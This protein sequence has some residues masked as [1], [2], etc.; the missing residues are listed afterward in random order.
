MNRP[1]K[2]LIWVV[3]VLVAIA[4]VATIAWRTQ[5]ERIASG[6]GRLVTAKW[7]AARHLRI[8]V[9]DISGSIIGDISVKDLRITYTGSG[10]P[11]LLVSASSAHARYDLSSLFTGAPTFSLIEATSPRLVLPL[12]PDGKLILPTGDAPP[13][14]QGKGARVEIQAIRASD[15]S[16]VIEAAKPWIIK[17]SLLAGSFAAAGNVSTVTISQADLSYG[18][19]ARI[20]RL[21][22]TV[23]ASP[24]RVELDHVQAVTPTT[25]VG[26]TGFFG[27]GTN[28]SLALAVSIDS[29]SIAEIPALAGQESTKPVPGRV[30][31][32]ANIAGRREHVAVDVALDG[33]VQGWSVDSLAAAG[34]YADSSVAVRSFG[35]TLNGSR[36]TL[37]GELTLSKLPTYAGVVTFERI[38]LAR[39][40]P[41]DS[42][43]YSTDFNGSVAFEGRGFDPKNIEVVTHPELRA[44]RYRQWAFDSAGGRVDVAPAKVVIDSLF[45]ML[46]ATRVKAAGTVAFD[47]A[48]DLGLEMHCPDLGELRSYHKMDGLTGEVTATATFRGSK[49]STA[50]AI[51]S[52]GRGIDYNGAY[53]ESL[54][55]D[56]DLAQARQRWSGRGSVLA[57]TLDLHGFKAGKLAGN[58]SLDDSIVTIE[59]LAVTRPDGA[60]LGASGRATLRKPGFLLGIDSLSIEMAAYTWRNQEPIAVDFR[61]DSLAVSSFEMASEMGKV[62]FS[63]SS[64]ARGRYQLET[65]VEDFDLAL[66]AKALRLDIPTGKLALDLSARGS[67]TEIGF[68]LGFEVREG[69]LRSFKFASLAGKIGYDGKTLGITSI[70]LKENGGSVLVT[71]VVPVDLAP[72]RIGA[73]AKAGKLP[74]LVNDLGRVTIA[75]RDIDISIFAPIAPQLAK[76]KGLAELDF[77]LSGARDNPRITSRGSLTGATYGQTAVGDVSWNLAVGDSTLRLES[78]D[79]VSAREHVNVAGSMPLVLS[80]LPSAIAFPARPIDMRLKAE[81]G[82]LGMLCELFPKIKVCSGTYGAD[83]AIGGTLADPTFTGNATLSGAQL[84][85]EG[86]PQ[87]LAGISLDVTASGKRFDI[88]RMTAE[89][90]AVKTQG[91]FLLEGVKITD[92]NFAVALKEFAVTEFEDFY[93]VLSG[94]ITIKAQQIERVGPV[95][96]IEGNLTVKEGEYYYTAQQAGAGGGGMGPEAAP[97]WTMNIDVEVPHD[98]WVKG[99]VIDAELQG[100]LNVAKDEQGLLALGTMRTLRGT[101]YLANND[102]RISRAEFRFTDVKSLKNV[103]IDLEATS[104]VLDEQITIDAKGNMDNLDI[105]ATSESGWSE[106]Q[107]FEALTLR[108]GAPS[109]VGEPKSKFFSDEFLRSWGLALV[110]R[111][112]SGVARDLKLDQFGVEIGNVGDGSLLSATRVTFGKYVSD[113]VY[114]QYTQSL[115]ALYGNSGKLI[116][117]DLAFPER[118]FQAEYR[119]S[120]KMS[121]QGEAGTVGGLGYFDVDLKFTYGY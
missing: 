2:I 18:Q 24:D 56:V 69:E 111:F 121:M 86:V 72:D 23:R 92:W 53:L 76:V 116:Q 3:A 57:K 19:K 45:A 66:L 105:S 83:L 71:G 39:F 95:P 104:R 54:M 100:S 15:L 52:L 96:R 120:E 1:A 112:G 90:G 117:Q 4:A 32:R 37:S 40:A 31:G 115:G 75:A 78:L 118:Q 98:F 46:N 26:V 67:A 64:F 80:V 35:V 42:E 9:G 109:V 88:T 20:S 84:R 51:K 38:D 6:V 60:L 74:E 10:G 73:L 93:A 13:G 102:F 94:N 82:N 50:F 68:D 77:D 108:R 8:E 81:N 49:D 22:G 70:S 34:V 63:N 58:V 103:Y 47:G 85:F 61:P 25:G 87:D 110:N 27:I 99:S 41:K 43:K 30:K 91:F 97:T 5:G 89:D 107:I 21:S 12:G 65:H 114:L 119:L 48:I 62:S 106:T 44:G 29:L 28:D 14:P 36:I 59:H 16:A 101:F 7:G 17:S 11:R 55:V 79:I 113:K 33:N